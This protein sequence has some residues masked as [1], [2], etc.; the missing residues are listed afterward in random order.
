VQSLAAALL[1]SSG[2]PQDLLS[3]APAAKWAFFSL[4]AFAGAALALAV[5]GVLLM[6][7]SWSPRMRDLGCAFA[8]YGLQALFSLVLTLG[9]CALAFVFALELIEKD[10]HFRAGLDEWLGAQRWA[11][12]LLP[13]GSAAVAWGVAAA[14]LDWLGKRLLAVRGWHQAALRLFVRKVVFRSVPLQAPAGSIVSPDVLRTRAKWMD[15]PFGTDIP[16]KRVTG[17]DLAS[18][19]LRIRL[20]TR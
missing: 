13:L 7:R 5:I 6:T 12:D 15:T 1:E 2:R 8:Y 9:L 20:L 3:A 11:R 19:K 14:V 16:G 10:E 17:W 18:L 4:A